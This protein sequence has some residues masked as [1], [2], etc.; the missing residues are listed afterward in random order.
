MTALWLG[1]AVLT[2]MAVSIVFWPLLKNYRESKQQP[3]DVDR[4]QQNIEIFKERLSELEKEC[5]LGTLSQA[6]FDELKLELERNLLIDAETNQRKDPVLKMG[7]SQLVTIMLLALLVPA[8]SFGLY[9]YLGR[10]VDL[11][12][13][14]SM[15]AW[16]D[17]F[18]NA[19]ITLEDAMAQLEAEL[20]RRPENPEGWYLLATTRMNL[21]QFDLAAAA[22]AQ[23]ALHLPEASP[24]LAGVL[25]QQAQAL[26]F[27]KGGKMDDD[28]LALT[29]QSLQLNPTEITSLGLL[30]IAAFESE[31]YASAIE[32]WQAALSNAEGN[33][34]ESLRNGI[35]RAR[36]QLQSLTPDAKDQATEGAFVRV[37][38]DLDESILTE[39][40]GEQT[41]FVFARPAGQRM[42]ITA[43]R[44]QVNQLPAEVRLDESSTLMPNMSLA[45]FE[46]VDLVARIS[47]T[48]NAEEGSGDFKGSLS[49]VKVSNDEVIRLII[50]ERID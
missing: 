17:S 2:L 18:N 26:F 48:G 34:A 46:E 14:L 28:V 42:P 27:A 47:V 16:N 41:V 39:I 7:S 20:A 4:I 45:D 19:D 11:E 29:D 50:S 31:N 1:I 8:S 9:A 3:V 23:S 13:S 15:N 10:A 30:G 33:A 37:Y 43:I 32:Y 21:N 49:S 5:S 40:T 38:I 24:E 36:V 44:M 22:F 35:E 12:T 25:G 6:D